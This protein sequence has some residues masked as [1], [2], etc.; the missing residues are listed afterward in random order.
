MAAQ[1]A[2]TESNRSSVHR[3]S[4]AVVGFFLLAM[5][6]SACGGPDKAAAK[7]HVQMA[8][9][10]LKMRQY[11]AALE[12]LNKAL[13]ADPENFEARFLMS[14]SFYNTAR[15]EEAAKIMSKLYEE[16][17]GIEK[18]R[19]GLAYMRKDQALYDQAIKLFESIPMSPALYL[20]IAECLTGVGRHDEAANMLG[21]L[22]A[23]NPWDTKAYHQFSRLESKRKREDSA[24]LW[25]DFYRGNEK[26]REAERLALRAEHEGNMPGAMLSRGRNFYRSGRLFPGLKMLEAAVKAEPKMAPA[27]LTIGRILTDLGQSADAVAVIEKALSIKGDMPNWKKRLE[28]AKAQLELFK[29]KTRSILEMADQYASQTKPDLARA[30]VLFEAD[31]TQKDVATMRLVLKYFNKPE[32]AFIRVWAW[33]NIV[34]TD[35]KNASFTAALKAETTQ[36]AVELK[37]PAGG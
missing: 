37:L 9:T 24:K 34:L 18:V 8:E 33:R 2:L 13:A 7:K 1:D 20:P 10:Q 19:T 5:S 17:P 21:E 14:E 22:L 30:V 4:G 27:L 16:F 23:D 6:I 11:T 36:L 15:V 28:E 32:D 3:H 26:L 25:G 29:G 12:F 35:P 31:R